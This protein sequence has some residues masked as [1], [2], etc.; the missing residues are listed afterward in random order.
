MTSYSELPYLIVELANTHGGSEEV[1]SD[2]ISE[3][4]NLDYLNKGIKFQIFSPNKIALPDFEWFPVYRKLFF[5]KEAWKRLI[6]NAGKHGDVWVDVFDAYG[7]EVAS[8]NIDQIQGFK[9]Q[10]SVLE[11]IEVYDALANLDLSE[12]RLIINVSGLDVS[13]IQVATAKF[14]NICK[15]LIVQIG[16]QSYPTEIKDTA[17]NKI[18]VIRAALP[19][20]PICMADHSGAETEFSTRVPVYAFMQ[21]CSYIEKHFCLDRNTAKYDGY[22]S[23]NFVQM[24]EVCQKIKEAALALQGR[25]VSEA[26]AEYLAKSVQIPVLKQDMRI[27]ELVSV[28]NFAYRRTAQQGLDAKQIA[29]Q[30]EKWQVLSKGKQA[31]TTI[32]VEDFKTANVAVIVAGRMKST[33]LPQKAILSIAGMSS[34]ERCLSQCLAISG[35][36]Q[37]ILATSNLDADAILEKYTL[38]GEAKFWKGDPD[39]V[40]SRYLGACDNY[41]VDVVVRVTAD[42]PM[43][44]PEIIEHLLAKHFEAGA[45]Y[46]AAKEC[47]VGSSGEIIN[48]SAL[49]KVVEYFGAA[50][51]SEYMTWYFQNNPSHFKLNIV[52]LPKNLLRD[53]RMTLDYPEDLLMFES[54]YSR[55]GNDRNH[56]S[57]SEVFAVL[58]ESSEISAHNKHL[59]LKYRTDQ[60]LIDLL[61]RETKIK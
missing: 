34:V 35:V 23:L 13:N 48:V 2:L 33:R 39:D 10:A 16:Y 25:F 30:Q 43:I 26:E 27:G 55:L 46:T 7:V 49:R 4:G 38:D 1:L 15:N 24:S 45:D 11:N 44:L 6:L 28:S 54:L 31:L 51:Y 3:F 52:P 20:V 60:E 57:A 5:D 61:D 9:I 32:R 19:G 18:P 58:D 8:D 50:P 29:Q 36:S 56:F 59:T 42:C 21:G 12:K 53:Y 17:L 22:S 47:A 40:I 41:G 37:V 14:N